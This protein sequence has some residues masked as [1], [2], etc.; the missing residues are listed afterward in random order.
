VAFRTCPEEKSRVV[1]QLG[2]SH[3]K[4]ALRVAKMVE[5]DV[6][7]IDINMGCPKT[8]SV[9]GGM[10]AALLKQPELVKSIL[11]E[12]VTHL[13][14]PVTCKIRCLDTIEDTIKFAKMCQSTGKYQP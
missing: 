2:T 10:G 3:P 7:A 8:F 12:L 6:A 14:I 9:S 1:F 4:R 13:T 5:R 11:T